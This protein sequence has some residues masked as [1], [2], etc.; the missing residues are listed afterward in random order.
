MAFNLVADTSRGLAELDLPEYD[1]VSNAPAQ[2]GTLVYVTGDGATTPE[3]AYLRT[4]GSYSQIGT[5]GSSGTEI[6]VARKTSNQA[7]STTGSWVTVEFDTTPVSTLSGVST[8]NNQFV[9]PKN[10]LYRIHARLNTNFGNSSSTDA[11]LQETTDAVTLAESNTGNGSSSNDTH[12]LESVENLT[13]S[14]AVE[15]QGQTDQTS[16]SSDFGGAEGQTEMIIE[17]LGS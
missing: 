16:G 14:A 1:D 17:Y 3:G 4:A 12:V 15:L 5:G 7:N 9:P 6:A 11:R 10:G 13:T 8:T 2:D